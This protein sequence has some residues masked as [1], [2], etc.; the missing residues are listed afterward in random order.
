MSENVFVNDSKSSTNILVGYGNPSPSILNSR[1]III[2]DSKGESRNRTVGN[3]PSGGVVRRMENTFGST[4][5]GAGELSGR[6]VDQSIEASND[7]VVPNGCVIFGSNVPVANGGATQ[8][9]T[10][11]HLIFDNLVGVGG[12]P[13]AADTSIFIWYNGVRYSLHATVV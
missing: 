2:G 6:R 11:N 8:L 4:I 10:N 5:I 1:N 3:P 7:T 13:A 12:A 9:N